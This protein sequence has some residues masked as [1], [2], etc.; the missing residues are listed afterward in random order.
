VPNKTKQNKVPERREVHRKRA[1][2][3]FRDF[4]FR[5]SLNMHVRKLAGGKPSER[6][7]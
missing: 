6:R 3:L 5:V 4:L 2:K 1:L 7:K